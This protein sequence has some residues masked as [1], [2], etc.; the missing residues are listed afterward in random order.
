MDLEAD[1]TYSDR[2]GVKIELPNLV[3]NQLCQLHVFIAWNL[4][5]HDFDASTWYAVDQ[6][7]E[8]ILIHEELL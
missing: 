6:R 4:I 2:E 1:L 5:T 8:Q 7:A 3:R